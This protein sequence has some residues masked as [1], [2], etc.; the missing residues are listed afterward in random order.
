MACQSNRRPCAVRQRS[1]HGPRAVYQSSRHSPCAF[2]PRHYERFPPCHPWQRPPRVGFSPPD[3]GPSPL[4]NGEGRQPEVDSRTWPLVVCYLSADRVLLRRQ[5]HVAAACAACL[6]A[7][8][9]SRLLGYQHAASEPAHRNDP[10]RTA[11]DI[12]NRK[13]IGRDEG[14]SWHMAAA[15]IAG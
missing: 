10:R 13:S 5:G 7:E 14:R 1:G 8:R 4:P 2:G 3:Q 9:L 11:G 15:P 12:A 6:A